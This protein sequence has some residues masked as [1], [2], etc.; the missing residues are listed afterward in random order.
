MSSSGMGRD[1]HSLMLSFQ[2]FSA[3]HRVAHLS[4]VPRRMVVEGLYW[5]VTCPSHASFR[6]LTVARR[7]S[8]GFHKE[9]G[10]GPHPVVGIV[11][12]IEDAKKFPQALGFESLDRFF[13]SWSGIHISQR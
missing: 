6:L 11:L 12:Q 4:K 7:G 10:L 2:H 8:C 5:R 9:V 13:Q 1:V 3:D